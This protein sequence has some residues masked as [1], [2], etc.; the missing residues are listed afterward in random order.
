MK[1]MSPAVLIAIIAVVIAI[2]LMVIYTFC[3]C[4]RPNYRKCSCHLR[5][6]F[7]EDIDLQRNKSA[8]HSRY[9]FA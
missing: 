3:M 6:I 8:V 4:T 7:R 5:R 2:L 9:R 1:K